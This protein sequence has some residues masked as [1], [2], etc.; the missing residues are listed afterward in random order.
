MEKKTRFDSP[1]DCSGKAAAVFINV[2]M[3]TMAE[4]AITT[5][6]TETKSDKNALGNRT[7]ESV[8]SDI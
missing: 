1:A 7:K 8:T 3:T 6:R 2:P 5:N 4:L